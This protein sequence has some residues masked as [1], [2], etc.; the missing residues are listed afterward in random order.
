MRLTI[1]LDRDTTRRLIQASIRDNRPAGWQ[2]EHVL[3]EAL[4]RRFS[5]EEGA[6]AP[7]AD[8]REAVPA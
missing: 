3:R 7:E 2:A 6:P 8:S 4:L 5:D 1:E